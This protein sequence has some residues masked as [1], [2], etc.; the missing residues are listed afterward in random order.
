MTAPAAAV[1][2]AVRRVLAVAALALAC[3]LALGLLPGGRY[4]PAVTVGPYLLPAA[5]T[6]PSW[7]PHGPNRPV[8][9]GGPGRRPA[10]AA[11]QAGAARCSAIELPPSTTR[12]CPVT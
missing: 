1:R 9:G 12:H 3:L 2:S 5:P 6:V 10:R 11:G 4:A 7:H 8:K